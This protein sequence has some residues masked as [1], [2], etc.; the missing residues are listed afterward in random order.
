VL[1]KVGE[2]RDAASGQRVEEIADVWEVL[3][4]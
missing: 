4:V 3:A 1:S 2:L